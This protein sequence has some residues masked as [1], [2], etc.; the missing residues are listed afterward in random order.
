MLVWTISFGMLRVT[1]SQEN[2]R[3]GLAFSSY[4]SSAKYISDCWDISDF[5][6][7]NLGLWLS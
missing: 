2:A 7:F 6:S 4:G 1:N 3:I 5:I